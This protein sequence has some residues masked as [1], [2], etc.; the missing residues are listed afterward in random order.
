MT[1]FD[2]DAATWSALNRLLDEALDVAPDGREAWIEGLSPEYEALKPRLR[3]LLFRALAPTGTEPGLETLPKLLETSRPGAVPVPAEG[4]A[5]LRA[6]LAPGAPLGRFEIRG[7]LGAGGMGRVYRA[8]EPLLGREVAIKALAHAFREDPTSLA[9]VEREARV[10]AT[11]NHPNIAGIHGFELI[12]GAP[13][14][15]LELVEGETL[16]ER[17]RRGPLPTAEAVSLATQI[18]SALEEAHRK[19]VVHRDLK[20]SNLKVR[21]DRRV[22]VLD[23][24][25]AKAVPGSGTLPSGEAGATASGL[26]RGTA[27]YMSPEQIRGEAVDARAD[28]WAFGCLLYEMLTGER[29]FG[30]SSSA[31]VMAAALRDDVNWSRLPADTP[32]ALRRLTRRCLVRDRKD[33]LQDIGDARIELQ[34]L[35]RG[36]SEEAA[37]PVSPPSGRGLRSPWAILAAG[38]GLLALGI[39]LTSSRSS[40]LPRA[41]TARLGLELPQGL[42]LEQDYAAPYALAPD[43]SRLVVVARQQGPARLHVRDLG[44]TDA[45]PLAGTEDAWQPFFSPDGREVAFFADRKL[46]TVAL[47]DG[48]VRPLAE[49]GD[50][51]R[52]G[53]WSPDGSIL[54][55]PSYNTGLSRLAPTSGEMTSLTHLDLRGGESTHRWPQVLPG[56]RWALFT[57]GFDGESFDDAAIEAVSLETGERR[58]LV[59]GGAFGRYTSGRLLYTQAGRLLAA[60][61]AL[62]P[63]ALEDQAEVVLESIRYDPRNGSTHLSVS[64]SGTLLYGRLHPAA[65]EHHLAW[66]D[67]GGRITRL[68]DVPRRFREPRVSPD[69]RRIAVVIGPAAGSDLWVVDTATSTFSRLSFGLS[70]RR[71]VWTPD[72]RGIT[73]ATRVGGRSQLQTLAV[74]GGGPPEVLFE[75]QNRVY[76]SDWSGDGRALLFQER[77]PETGWDLRLLEHPGAGRPGEARDLSARPFHETNGALSPDSR[78]VAYESDEVDGVVE[79]YVM[80]RAD[81]SLR[82]KLTTQGANWPRWGRGGELYY[83]VGPRVHPGDRRLA[84]GLH[85]IEVRSAGGRLSVGPTSPV[86]PAAVRGPQLFD[87]LLVASFAP[88]DVGNA[89]PADRFLLLETP[90]SSGPPTPAGPIVALNAFGAAGAPPGPASGP[91]P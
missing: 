6:D 21:T 17:L 33:R 91:R 84:E 30:G 58:R 29:P 80:A 87:R 88:Y 51:P 56:G 38:L 52:G 65:F 86:W 73:V 23:F 55:A 62:D 50:N 53:A 46:K 39:W 61:L 69:G 2:I 7:L 70:P 35:E 67:A 47:G 44:G 83:W 43:G 20:P 9:R 48:S 77:R 45:R 89:R 4:P 59:E 3:S 24:G 41:P 63:P 75:G 8:F 79:I 54:L 72:G 18:A 19:G 60:P 76:P 40:P 11:L 81:P 64:E 1:G 37:A 10:L 85:R 57:V 66:V 22:K 5:T 71:P 14:L 25:I 49:I 27:P 82:V 78:L 31:E 68:D 15:I 36:E 42:L 26:V 28:I 16:A 90:L 13:Y 34:I 12:E 74:A 32:G